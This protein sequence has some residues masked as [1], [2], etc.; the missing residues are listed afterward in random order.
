MAFKF[1]PRRLTGSWKGSKP[2]DFAALFEGG[3]MD[4]TFIT[5]KYDAARVTEHVGTDGT[6]TVVMN[7]DSKATATLVLSQGNPLNEYLSKLVPNAKIDFFPRGAFNF[8]ELG[9]TTKIKAPIAYIRNQAEVSYGNQVL[10]RSWE[11]GLVEAEIVAGGGE[12]L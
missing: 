6:V 1:N 9:G 11:F 8:E 12:E 5:V 3:W 2:R 7:A 10:G 4:G